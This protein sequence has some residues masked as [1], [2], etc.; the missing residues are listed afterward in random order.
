MTAISGDCAETKLGLSANDRQELI[1]NVNII[2]HS[3]A[4]VRF[5]EPLSYATQINIQSTIDLMDLAK[6]MKQ[7]Q[8]SSKYY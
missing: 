3:A 8:V 4:S 2:L 1:D 5:N 7:L 6:E